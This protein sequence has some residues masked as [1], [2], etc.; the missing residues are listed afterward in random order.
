MTYRS[1]LANTLV[2]SGAII[3]T[4]SGDPGASGPGRPLIGPRPPL[5]PPLLP[6]GEQP[7]SSPQSTPNQ[8]QEPSHPTTTLP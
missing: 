7:S 5:R 1:G 8:P 6:D 3:A 4:Q 2:K